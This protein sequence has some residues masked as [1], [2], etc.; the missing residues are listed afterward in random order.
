MNEMDHGWGL[1]GSWIIVLVVIS[2]V[3]WFI[4]EILKETN[5]LKPPKF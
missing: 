4:V 5:K 2:A 3:V 1:A